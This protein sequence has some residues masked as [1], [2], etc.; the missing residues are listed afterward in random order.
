MACACRRTEAA[1]LSGSVYAAARRRLCRV[2]AARRAAALRTRGPLVWAA[3]RADWLR[4]AADRRRAAPLA[5]RERAFRDAAL[6]PSRFSAPVIARDRVD[7]GRVRPCR[8]ARLA[9]AAL[10]FVFALALAGGRGSFTPARRAFESPIAI[11]CLVDRAPCL[12]RRTCSIS[13]R[14]NAPAW[15]VGAFPVRLAFLARL[16]VVFSGMGLISSPRSH[17]VTLH[18]RAFAVRRCLHDLFL[19]FRP[20]AK[21][22]GPLLRRSERDLPGCSASG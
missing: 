16:N 14:T 4:A 17:A 11:A 9:Y 18:G 8:P 7:A 10:C 1:A 6:R 2:R 20:V 3:R 19:F 22:P 13:S 15:V 5:C 21:G 12:P